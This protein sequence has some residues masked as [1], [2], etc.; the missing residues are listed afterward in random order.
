[1]ENDTIS[2]NVIST[3]LEENATPIDKEWR[4]FQE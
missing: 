2:E 1:M 4:Y 3:E